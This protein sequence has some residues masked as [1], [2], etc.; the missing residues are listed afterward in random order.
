MSNEPYRIV[1]IPLQADPPV[2]AGMRFQDLI[3]PAASIALDVFLSRHGKWLE[4]ALDIERALIL[5]GGILLARVRIQ[6]RSL[7]AWLMVIGVFL[8]RPRRYL[9]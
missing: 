1:A 9:P 8:C 7:P 4:P 5:S 6:S 2:V 3:W